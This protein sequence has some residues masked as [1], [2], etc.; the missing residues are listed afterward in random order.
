MVDDTSEPSPYQWIEEARVAHNK[1]KARYPIKA[2]INGELCF[3]WE[4]WT[5]HTRLWEKE[6]DPPADD[7]KQS[8]RRT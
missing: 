1:P 8:E 5:E 3:L 4:T 7:D 2:Y 6:K